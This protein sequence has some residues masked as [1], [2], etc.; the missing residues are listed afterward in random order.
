MA[1]KRPAHRR[2]TTGAPYRRAQKALFASGNVCARCGNAKGPI[3]R[4]ARCGHPAHQHLK[5]CPTHP[6]APSYGHIRDLQHGGSVRDPR[7][8]QLEHFGCNASAGA[9]SRAKPARSSWDW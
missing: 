4:D 1:D 9:R 7:N 5:G 6:L 2:G 3:V 8:R